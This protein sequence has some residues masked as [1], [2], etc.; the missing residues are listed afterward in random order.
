MSL[1][2]WLFGERGVPAH[3]K[4]ALDA[5]AAADEATSAARAAVRRYWN[6]R[7]KPDYQQ[8]EAQRLTRRR[9]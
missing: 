5:S 7:R 6:A 4:D 3:I 1:H 2:D 9:K 8:A